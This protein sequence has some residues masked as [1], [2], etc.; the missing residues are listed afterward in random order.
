[1]RQTQRFFPFLKKLFLSTLLSLPLIVSPII[2]GQA[3]AA[4]PAF[5]QV[6]AAQPQTNQTAV[7]VTFTKAQ[8]AGNTNILAIG[9]GDTTSNIVSVTDSKGNA[10]AVAAPTMHGS[11]QSQA[12]Y[13]AKNIAGAAVNANTVTVTFNAPA[14]FVDLRASEYSGLDATNPFDKFSSASGTSA[15]ATTASVSTAVAN[16]LI[17]GAGDTSGA[18]SAAGT[19]FTKRII[20]NPDSD[21]VED[22]I[23]TT[24]GSY[25]VTAKQSGAYVIQMASFK[26]SNTVAPTPTPTGIPTPTNTPTPT[27]L[28]T[29]TPTPTPTT[30][31]SASPTPTQIPTPTPTGTPNFPFAKS[32][33][34]NHRYLLDQNGNPYMIVG[35]S[36]HSLAVNLTEAQ[37]DQYFADRQSFG[38]NAAWMQVLVNSYAGGRADGTTYDGIGPFTSPNDFS[39]PNPVYFQRLHNMVNSAAQHGVTVFLDPMETA[40]WQSQYESNG[41]TKDFNF[42]VFLG[43]TFKDL[44]N[45]V[46]F[47]G[48]DYGGWTDPTQDAEVTAIANGIKS[49]DSNHMHTVQLNGTISSSLDDQN[50]AS[51]IN[52]NGAYTYYPTYDEV[53]HAYN[54]TPTMPTYM[55]E[56]NYEFENNTG[57]PATTDET[58]RRQEY[59]TATSGGNAGQIYGNCYSWDCAT[60]WADEQAHLDTSGATQLQ[61]MKNL[62]TAREWYNLVPDQTHTFLT[63]GAGTYDSA[64]DDVLQNDYATAAVTPDGGFGAVYVPTSRTISVNLNL[65]AG[66]INAQWFDP[67]NNTF[68][69]INGSPF[70]ANSGSVQFTTPGL[71]SEGN[72]DWL[73]VLDGNAV[74]DTTPPTIPTNLTVTATTGSTVGLSWTASTD[75]VNVAGYRIY[76]NGTQVGTSSTTSYTDSGL[77]QNTSYTYT[78]SSYDLAGNSSPQSDPVNATTT[79]ASP[80]P[81]TPAF[82]Q[83]NSTT[84]QSAQSTVTIPYSQAQ[85]SGNTNIIAIGFYNTAATI[86]SVTDT[87]GNTYSV[88]APLTL[89]A[90]MY[91]AIY[92]APNIKQAPAGANIITVK[93]STAVHYPDIRIQEYSG[94][95]QVSPFDVQSS[96]TGSPATATSGN[97]TTSK[98]TELLF[99][100]GSTSGVFSAAGSGYTLRIITN[101]DSD[102]IED[103]VVTATGTYS[104]T[105][106]QS[107]DE[108]MQ[109]AAFKAAGQS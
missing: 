63:A 48:N 35:D 38:I 89:S 5:V 66:P 102:I 28:P 32:V 42:G 79:T 107:G 70:A 95:D 36:P 87:E 19:G 59:W 53:L 62:F 81:T 24:I 108:V 103:K 6:V 84:P 71:N 58:L 22:K 93:F 74:A 12:I 44:P 100:S 83:L 85:T 52:M 1:M 13:Y 73:L 37:A 64:Q 34:A 17:F 56:A 49:V 31:P 106:A 2:T 33:S 80:P 94:L 104:A 9:W 55:Q 69:A 61:Y 91:Q 7:T 86:T 98:P 75:N 68:H 105:A 21:I 54:Q 88:A 10:Y 47:T 30:I 40:G 67:S 96:A 39:T 23:V 60:S 57:G 4:G 41:V 14:A 109:V 29:A 99:A 50:W 16:E 43:N 76:R 82:V 92:Y 46:W 20:T 26:A 97:I 27:L 65:L 11:Q 25:S 45:I 8:T 77:A 90:S 51:I 3:N 15:T 72:G 18:F 78:V 101:P